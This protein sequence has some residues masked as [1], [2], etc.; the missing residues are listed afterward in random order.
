MGSTAVL[1]RS[2]RCAPH[3]HRCV[4]FDDPEA[5]RRR[6][7]AFLAA[8]LAA[9]ERVLY[10][11]ADGPQLVSGFGAAVERGQAQ[12]VTVEALYPAGDAIDP[13]QQLAIIAEA[14]RTAL[15]DGYRGLRVAADCTSLAGGAARTDA[16]ARWE[17]LADRHISGNPVS[18]LCGFH[19]DRLSAPEIAAVACMHPVLE[20]VQVPF[21]LY[22]AGDAT[23]GA[24][25]DGEIDM[26]AA[27]LFV[28]AL[29]RV[30]PRPVD[31][32]VL[33]DCRGLSFIDHR[34]MFA[35]DARMRQLGAAG[36]LY[37]G[38]G[39]ML[40]TLIDL[41]GLRQLRVVDG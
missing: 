41:L 21:R 12:A 38:D 29:G 20:Q 18:G 23:F 14:T 25:L 33:I 28:A 31:G 34:A 36:T 11:G 1:D 37:T 10:V 24:V 32:E 7:A 15:A 5:F 6:C 3:E 2:G 27:A 30:E 39:A 40:R 22:S 16:F 26:A 17:H 13:P 4:V 19:R 8:G 9:G 35:L